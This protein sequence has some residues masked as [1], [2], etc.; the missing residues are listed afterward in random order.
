[1]APDGSFHPATDKSEVIKLLEDVVTNDRAQTSAHSTEVEN[2]SETCLVVDGME[3]IQ[4]LM[5]VKNFKTCKGFATFFVKLVDSQARGYCR[6][7]VIFDNYIKKASMKEQARER[8]KGD[9]EKF[10]KSYIVPDSYVSCQHQHEEFA[11]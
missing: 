6:V 11:N 5:T 4:A 8:R 2:G 3:I 1:M 10:P 7:R 9:K